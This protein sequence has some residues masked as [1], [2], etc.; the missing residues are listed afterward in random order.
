M[1]S[2]GE[3]F[4]QQEAARKG[5][6]IPLPDHRL[7]VRFLPQYE[8]YRSRW[9]IGDPTSYTHLS[10]W[11]SRASGQQ[12]GSADGRQFW[13]SLMRICG[14]DPKPYKDCSRD[15]RFL[16]VQHYYP[17][18]ALPSLA[19]RVFHLTPL[20][21]GW[22]TSPGMV[23][24]GGEVQKAFYGPSHDLANTKWMAWQLEN[25]G[26]PSVRFCD[27]VRGVHTDKFR[28]G[29]DLLGCQPIYASS[30]VVAENRPRQVSIFDCMQRKGR[31][32]V[33]R[34][35]VED[36]TDEQEEIDNLVIKRLRSEFASK[37]V[38]VEEL[39]SKRKEDAQFVLQM[40]FDQRSEVEG[41]RAQS[42]EDQQLIEQ[43]QTD[44][45]RLKKRV[46][47]DERRLAEQDQK[48]AQQQKRVNTELLDRPAHSYDTVPSWVS[49]VR[50]R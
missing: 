36:I 43:L 17:Q 13:L 12:V 4:L 48:M 40:Q 44:I 35:R 38:E 1:P 27:A 24:F 16:T 14:Y 26:V 39:H 50:R 8:E 32:A 6:A 30:G 10:E 47:A 18:H 28:G 29:L 23:V 25:P 5:L 9:W 3:K 37:V 21:A 20:E 49:Y 19:A 15:E 31:S 7:S 45:K 34:A 42:K 11:F 22:Q 2:V 46:A 33:K 41:L